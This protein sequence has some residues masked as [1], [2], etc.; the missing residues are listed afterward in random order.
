MRLI[1][2]ADAQTAMLILYRACLTLLATRGIAPENGESP[3]PFAQRVN[4]LIANDD[5]ETFARAV[6]RCAYSRAEA[7]REAVVAGRRAYQ[8]FERSLT[9]AEKLKYTLRRLVK[10]LGDFTAIP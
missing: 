6:E 1:A 9:L 10:G 5:F 4:T 7:K 2:R 8:T 3:I